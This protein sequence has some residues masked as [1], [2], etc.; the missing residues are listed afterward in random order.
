MPAGGPEIGNAYINVIPKL[1]GSPEALGNE[2]GSKM[3]GGLK[4]AIGVGAVAVGNILA[5]MVTSVASSIGEQITKTFWNYADYEQLVGGVDTIFKESSAQVQANAQAAFAT[6]GMSANQYMENVTGFSASL[7]RSLDGDTQKAASVADM[8]MRDMS[9]NANKMGTDMGRITDAY[10]GFAR[11]NYTMLDNLQLGYSGSREGM[12][13]LL[14]DAEA[15]SGV[16]Y[17][18]GNYSDV[19]EAIHV[20]QEDMG[21]A[22]TTMLEG[23]ATISGSLNQLNAAWENFLT[24]IGD[25]GK[26]MDIGTVTQNLV[27]ALTAA[28]KNV[29]PAL[30]TIAMTIAT[31]LPG[32]FAEAIAIVLPQ[33]QEAITAQFGEGAGSLFGDWVTSA[34][35]LVGL[36]GDAFSSIVDIV[37]QAMPAIQGIILPVLENLVTAGISFY[38]TIMAIV[39][40]LLDFISANVMPVVLQLVEQLTPI[41]TT[42]VNDIGSGFVIIKT[43]VEEAM[44][45]IMAAMTEAWPYIQAVIETVMPIIGAAVIPTWEMIKAVIGGIMGAIKAVISTTWN[46]ITSV[47][48]TAAGAISSIIS[49]LTSVVA[50]VSSIFNGVKNAIMTPINTAKN[51]IQ[52]AVNTI[53]SIFNGLQLKIPL[54]KIPKIDI[55]GGEAPWGIGGQGRLPSFHVSWA[56]HGGIVDDMTLIGAGERGP[57]LIWPGYEPYLTQYADAIAQR[58]DADGGDARLLVSWLAANLGPIIET[59]APTATPR[60]FGRMVRSVV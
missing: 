38:E 52:T 47:I 25:G 51:A 12:Q 60:E 37:V 31:A 35:E 44:A 39:N 48:S 27:F 59:Y 7:I 6:A 43:N 32:A 56:A 26:T 40:P 50:T 11:E 4:G 30:A 5:N 1:E 15:I 42:I 29:V 9:D 22:G 49:G 13:Q 57:E 18:I 45:A 20:I 3:S 46:I 24:A 41:I 21:I 2:F 55:D 23:S 8:A 19:I 33:M 34:N 16:H 58:M 17:D 14:Q 53:K 10:Q 36:L 28:A 54:P